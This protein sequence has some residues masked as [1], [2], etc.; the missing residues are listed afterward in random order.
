[1]P[2]SE[3]GA[4]GI[5]SVR[6]VER[7]MGILTALSKADGPMSITELARAVDLPY[8]TAQRLLLVHERSGFVQKD[9]HMY[10][11]GPAVVTLAGA[12]LAGDSLVR[13]AQP[14]LDELA[15]YSGET[16]SLHVR[17]GSDRVVVMWRPSVHP[18]G[19][20]FQ[21]GQRRPL[22]V[23]AAGYVLSA[24]I[25]PEELQQL[26]EAHGELRL[27]DGSVLSPEQWHERL[28]QA[29]QRGFAVSRGDSILGSVSVAAPVRRP[30]EG[31]IAAV[32]ISAAEFRINDEKVANF[33][34]AVR[35]AAQEISRLYLRG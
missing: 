11:L 23:G 8:A 26:L 14:V 16:V 5:S 18:L 21:V 13:A 4:R 10:R 9:R 19:Y 34:L 33:A 3:R 22:L 29:R 12:Y 25:P 20:V 15:E 27:A 7:A 32:T 17:Q 30:G 2:I 1:M 31:V 6:S 24:D 28:Q 35:Q